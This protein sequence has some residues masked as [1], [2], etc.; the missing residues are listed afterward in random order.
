MSAATSQRELMTMAGLNLIQQALSIYDRDLR[1]VFC[2]HG[3]RRM[4]D[5]PEVLSQPGTPFASVTRHLYEAGEYGPVPDIDRAVQARL[6]RARRLQPYYL[7]RTRSNGRVVGV[8]GAPLPEGGWVTVYTDITETKRQETLLRARSEELSE[9]L[10]AR[11]E[12]LAAANRNLTAMN[13]ALEE[14]KR[15]LTLM[16][17]RSRLTTET[18]PAHIS[19]ISPAGRYTYSNKQMNRIMPGRPDDILGQPVAAVLGVQAYDAVRPYLEAALRDARPSTFEFTDERS[20][21]RIRTALTPDGAGG[22]YA[23]SMDITE[24]SQTREALLQNRQRELAAQVTSGMAHDFSNLL[25]IILGLQSRLEKMEALPDK[26]RTMVG[27]TLAAAKRGGRLLNRLA[28]M[29]GGREHSPSATCW[30]DFL[31]DF[32]T[33]A[34]SALPE[35]VILRIEDQV[36]DTRLW[37]D[38]GMLQDSLLNLVLNARD[39]IGPVPGEIRICA[40]CEQGTWLRIEVSDTGPGFSDS[41]LAHALDPFFTTKGGEGSGLGLSMVHDMTQ[42]SGG[43]M[44]LAND[45]GARVTLLLPWREAPQP[46]TPGVVLLVEDS[47]DLRSS[48]RDMLVETGHPVIEAASAA[49]A[50][51]IAAAVPDLSLILSD[52][53]LEGGDTGIDLFDRLPE[54]APPC[55]MMTSLRPDHPLHRAART[56]GPVLKKPFDAAALAAFLSRGPSAA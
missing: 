30:G 23:M 37:L 22:A 40:C 41:A 5:L 42:R 15:E 24:E 9:Q 2:N 39:S 13:T 38:A 51:E 31:K 50:L 53:T 8:E 29:T 19:H 1:L 11:A 3:F 28:D 55:V 43:Q 16:E 56:R 54:G 27:A 25:T 45:N 12:D 52:L 6:A 33:L 18:M 10:L 17:A 34:G 48:I 7:E 4:F 44:S 32:A 46:A 14:A 47:P 49:E 35:E 26:A 36:G 21:R 20:A